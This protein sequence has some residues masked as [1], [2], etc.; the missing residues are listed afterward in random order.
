MMQMKK[1]FIEEKRVDKV[2]ISLQRTANAC[3][4]QARSTKNFLLYDSRA[5]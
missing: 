3:S 5:V 1:S 4:R 2:H